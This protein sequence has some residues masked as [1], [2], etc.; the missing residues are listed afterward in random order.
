MFWKI[1]L[2]SG[3]WWFL[4]LKTQFW[5]RQVCKNHLQPWPVSTVPARVYGDIRS[6]W[7]WIGHILRK[8]ANP[9]PK[10]QS[11]RPQREN[12]SVV[13]R[14]QPGKELWKQKWRTWTTAGAPSIGW[15][16]TDRGGV[17]SLLPYTPAGMTGS[18]QLRKAH[19]VGLPETNYFKMVLFFF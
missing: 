10:L 19:T 17:A 6:D 14:R 16:V 15:W 9:S 18:N 13:D 8:D 5:G 4:F 12:G 11:T 3:F 7:G 2:C 1:M